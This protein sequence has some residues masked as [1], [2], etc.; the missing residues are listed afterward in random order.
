ME[1]LDGLK[2]RIAEQFRYVDETA[3]IV[4]KGHLLIEESLDSIISTF[5][6]H[7]E[8]VKRANLRFGQKISVAR[9]MSLDEQGNEMWELAVR[10]NDLRNEIAHSLHSPK[11]AAKTQAVIDLYFRLAGEIPNGLRGQAEHIALGIAIYFFL[12]FLSSFQTEVH[13]FR[14]SVTHQSVI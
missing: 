3:L 5:V 4:L 11:R 1:G 14:K 13:R 2:Q 10:L 6:F 9:S 12:G 7:P 8:F